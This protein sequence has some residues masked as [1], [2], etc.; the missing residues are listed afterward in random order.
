VELNAWVR[1]V[2][3]AAILGAVVWW[4]G[5][6]PFV[7]GLSAVDA[8]AAAAALGAGAVATVCCAWRWRVTAAAAGVALPWRG[9]LAAYYQSQFLN[10]TLPTGVVGDVER[11]VRHGRGIGDLR[12][13]TRVVLAERGTGLAAQVA[14]AAAAL[15]LVPPP[16]SL[17]WLPAALV[18]AV[19]A[20][21]AVLVTF[22]PAATRA[23][24]P[25]GGA[26]G[27]A[28]PLRV[29]GGPTWGARA[30]GAAVVA[31]SSGV[32]LAG[33]LA[34]FLIAARAAGAGAPLAS[35]L[36]LTLLA[37]L[38][39][40]VPLSIAGWGPREGVAAWVFG[41]AGLGA[42]QGVAAAVAY[43]VLS[44]IG[45]LPGA[46]VLLGRLAARRAVGS[47]A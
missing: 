27:I 2:G 45:V 19:V 23:V 8:P 14:L 36:P 39:M 41:A 30:A 32:A 33:H 34:V 35:L 29:G 21:V 46:L 38:A 15:L 5:T 10:A 28:G 26:T 1:A 40:A 4:V 7:V 24:A 11:A 44:L 37:L 18:T 25:S 12:L 43:G 6:G 22:A 9:A 42:T 31:A 47:V 16:L 17:P 13:G 20:G 3:G